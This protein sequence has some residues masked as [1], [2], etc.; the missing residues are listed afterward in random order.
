[1]AIPTQEQIS[2]A[3]KKC[4]TNLCAWAKVRGY[5][6]PTVWNTA[7]R[8]AGRD[9]RPP[10]GGFARQIIKELTEYVAANNQNH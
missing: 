7:K 2:Q 8:W 1:M 10:H 5:K 9:D 4:D 6:Y 3:L